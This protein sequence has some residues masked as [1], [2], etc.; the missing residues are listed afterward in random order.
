[1]E[2]SEDLSSSNEGKKVCKHVAV[3]RYSGKYYSNSRAVSFLPYFPLSISL[4]SRF[5]VPVR[6]TAG[7][8]LSKGGPPAPNR[9]FSISC[10]GHSWPSAPDRVFSVPGGRVIPK[11]ISPG[12]QR[13]RLTVTSS[14]TAPDSAPSSSEQSPTLDLARP[15]L[16][17]REKCYFYIYQS[18]TD[19]RQHSYWLMM[20]KDV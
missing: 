20:F 6:G 19:I 10:A 3:A 13:G 9:V 7:S 4:F 15:L 2:E 1:V 12:L 11:H 18:Q 16:T 17:A 14:V 8:E 5:G